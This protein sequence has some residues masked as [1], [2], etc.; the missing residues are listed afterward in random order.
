MVLVLTS[1]VTNCQCSYESDAIKAGYC[2][3]PLELYSSDRSLTIIITKLVRE[4]LTPAAV[5]ISFSFRVL[6]KLNLYLIYKIK[7][8][9]FVTCIGQIKF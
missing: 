5:Y 3:Q 1:I 7:V 6:T 9:V 8:L 2:C 4:H